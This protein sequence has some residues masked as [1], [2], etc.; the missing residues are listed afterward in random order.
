MYI[1]ELIFI[2][3]ITTPKTAALYLCLLPSV[4]FFVVDNHQTEIL[5]HSWEY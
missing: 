1:S 2:T 5:L 4:Q 3:S